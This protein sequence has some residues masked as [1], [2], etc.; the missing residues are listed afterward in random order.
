MVLLPLALNLKCDINSYW[1][2]LG[3]KKSLCLGW[4]E[5]RYMFLW[6]RLTEDSLHYLLRN[7]LSALFLSFYR[8][9]EH[10]NLTEVNKGWLYG[11]RML[12]QLYVNQ[13]AVER[14]SPDAWEFCQRLSEL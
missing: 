4:A 9:L 11:L 13:N 6:V 12:Q 10:N 3:L 14:I 8:E 1:I 7:T 2:E 5:E